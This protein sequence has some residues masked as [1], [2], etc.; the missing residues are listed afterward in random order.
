MNKFDLNGAL[1]DISN[2]FYQWRI[3]WRLGIDDLLLRYTR[4]RLGP[5]WM[6]LS[7]AVYVGGL[8]LVWGTIFNIDLAAFFPYMAIGLVVWLFLSGTVG[9]AGQRTN[10]ERGYSG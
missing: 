9:E 7:L 6:T 5:L 3:W 10:K 2:G 1:I 8:G 4:T